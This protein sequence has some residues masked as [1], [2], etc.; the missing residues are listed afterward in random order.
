VA[1]WLLKTEP[2]TYGFDDLVREKRARWDGVANPVALRNLRAAAVGDAIVVYHT[3]D[4]K[5]A[6]GLAEVARAAYPDPEAVDGRL[7]VID[8]VP[9]RRFQ[10]PVTLAQ[11]KA[12]REFAG[13]PLVKQGRLSVVPLTD[14]QARWVVQLGGDLGDR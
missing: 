13:S 7:V 10:R 5:A 14:A 2:G 4:Q 6:V 12:A 3:G 1:T 11:I 9:V 8:I